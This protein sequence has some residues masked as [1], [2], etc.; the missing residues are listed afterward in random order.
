MHS[1]AHGAAGTTK[2]TTYSKLVG[3]GG[4]CSDSAT[5]LAAVRVS[6]NGTAEHVIVSNRIVNGAGAVSAIP[7]R[8]SGQMDEPT[9][10]TST[11]GRTPRD[12]VLL[13]SQ[14]RHVQGRKRA[15]GHD[16]V[17][18]LAAN[19]DTDEITL[20]VQGKEPRVLTK[21]VPTP[22]CLCMLG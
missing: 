4:L 8:P 17:L 11:L 12:F 9:W 15:A 14:P 7:L 13:D 22:V 3:Q 6:A 10:I 5:S 2:D 1:S 21:A 18:S 20:L 19:Q 16:G